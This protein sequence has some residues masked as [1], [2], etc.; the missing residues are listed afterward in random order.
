MWLSLLKSTRNVSSVLELGCNIGINLQALKGLLPKAQLAAVEINVKAY[1]YVRTSKPWVDIRNQSLLQGDLN[2]KADLVFT[3]GVLIH[4]APA[5]LARAYESMYESSNK[6]IAVCEYYNPTP[7][8]VEYR[9]YKKRL[10]KRDFAGDLMDKYPD[11]SLLD[12]GFIYRRD[13]NFSLDDPTWFLL[14]KA[15][16]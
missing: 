3:S 5:S 7:V 14:Q 2:I 8:E 13:P 9:G 16:T 11:L 10:F 6:Y 4:I 15:K 12:Y 1:E